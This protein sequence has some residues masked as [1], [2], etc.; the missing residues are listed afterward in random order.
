MEHYLKRIGYDGDRTPNAENLARLIRCHIE[1]VPFENLDFYRNPRELSLDCADLYDKVVTRRRGGVCCELNTL[2]HKLLT[3]LGY[4]A[5]P[6]LTRITLMPEPCPI[7]HECVITVLDGKRYYCDVGFGGPGPKGLVCMDEPEIQVVYGES[8]RARWD[9]C[10]GT[11]SKLMDGQWAPMLQLLDIPAN[12]AD[13]AIMLHYFTTHPGSRFV[14]LRT[15]N[16]CL[17]GGYLALT[18]NTF[19]GRRGGETFH[20]EVPEEQIPAL[21]REE[22]GLV[23]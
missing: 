22:F 9:G 17:P 4:D 12:V 6:V 14:N 21:L 10:I 7:S 20:R 3:D 13:F 15:I 16:L 23:I 8:Y 2:L 18:G 5:R 11:I 19:T 1:H